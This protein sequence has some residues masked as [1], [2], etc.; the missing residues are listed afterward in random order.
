MNFAP[1]WLFAI[2]LLGASSGAAD[3]IDD[4]LK[5]RLTEAVRNY[6]ENKRLTS[7]S[8]SLF[9]GDGSGFDFAVGRADVFKKKKATPRHIYTWASVTKP[10]TGLVV[11]KLIEQ[12]TL[13]LDDS[14]CHYISGF[15]NNLTVKDLLNHTTG[16]L[17]EKE[18]ENFLSNST[19]KNILNYLPF[20]FKSKIHRYANF[21]YAALGAVIEA[22]T[23]RAYRN[24]V[25]EYFR[26]I[27]GERIYF[28]NHTVGQTDSRFVKNYVRRYRRLYSHTPVEFGLWEPAA[29]AQTT[30]RALA[31]FLQVHMTNSFVKFLESHADRVEGFINRNG[32]RVGEYYSLG[33]R[34][35]YVDD[36][37]EYIYHNGFLYGVISSFYYFP[38]KQ[39]GFTAA[40]NMSSYPRA[41]LSLGGLY[42]IVEPIVDDEFNRRVAEYTASNGY[43]KGA[44]FYETIKNQGELLKEKIAEQ[45]EAYLQT[46]H[47]REAI[48]LFKLNN[49]VFSDSAE[50]YES[51]AE[52]YIQS[53]Y[54]E[55][56]AESLRK[57]LQVDP[58]LES[59]KR[60]L[61]HLT[62]E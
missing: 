32:Q 2:F 42:K 8:F 10:V 28:H 52:A 29:F 17:R 35:R 12:G 51:L 44:V 47:Y 13:A 62:A 5:N 43:L 30:S 15:P 36:Q 49:Y 20:Q 3:E 41:Y 14:V 16:F 26:N 1:I 25:D 31:R 37:L 24:V 19:Y 6:Q 59:L 55:L 18:N 45:A 56:A 50:T 60:I 23:G 22:A 46:K 34:L 39:V 61:E 54:N 21:N 58:E 11:L 4:G 57:G 7:L 9:Q 33:F 48:S 53:G 38:G 27:T 40:S